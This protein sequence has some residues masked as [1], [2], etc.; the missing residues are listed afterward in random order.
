MITKRENAMLTLADL[1]LYG[2]TILAIEFSKVFNLV[3]TEAVR[4]WGLYDWLIEGVQVWAVAGVVFKAYFDK[5]VTDRKNGGFAPRPTKP[6]AT[7]EPKD[8]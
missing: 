5:S 4:N 1:S 6:T 3:G 7:T 8:I 2:S